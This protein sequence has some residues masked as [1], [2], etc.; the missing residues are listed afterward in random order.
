[1]PVKVVSFN[2]FSS[3]LRKAHRNEVITDNVHWDVLGC[4][5][6]GTTLPDRSNKSNLLESCIIVEVSCTDDADELCCATGQATW[7]SFGEGAESCATA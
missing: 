4:P 2:G 3:A 1:M 7:V 6:G 5:D